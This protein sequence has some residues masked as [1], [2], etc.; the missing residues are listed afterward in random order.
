MQYYGLDNKLIDGAA[1]RNPVKWG[2]YTLTDIPIVSEEEARAKA[3]IFLVL[4]YGFI[5][6]FVRR[7]T[8]WLNSGGEFVVPLPEFRVISK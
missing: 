8:A 6:E 4:P 7:E 3:D 2:K 5:D 1:D